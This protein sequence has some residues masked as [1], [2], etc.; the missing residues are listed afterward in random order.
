MRKFLWVITITLSLVFLYIWQCSSPDFEL[1]TKSLKKRAPEIFKRITT[2][3]YPLDSEI[4]HVSD[5][6]FMQVNYG[7]DLILYVKDINN[8]IQQFEKNNIKLNSSE[9]NY[10]IIKNYKYTAEGKYLNL[11]END[12]S[13]NKANTLTFDTSLILFS[14]G[15]SKT[16]YSKNQKEFN[17]KIKADLCYKKDVLFFSNNKD[18]ILKKELVVIVPKDNL[19]WIHTLYSR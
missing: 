5:Y 13:N 12:L 11:C 2:I 16:V 4:Y 18:S 14:N 3:D 1:N 6:Q 17:N 15:N 9:M 7:T 10:P 8:L 19:I